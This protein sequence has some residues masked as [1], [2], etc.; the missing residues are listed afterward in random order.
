MNTTTARR[1][2]RARFLNWLGQ[3]AVCSPIG[4]VAVLIA[5]AIEPPTPSDA[6]GVIFILALFSFFAWIGGAGIASA[7][8]PAFNDDSSPAEMARDIYLIAPWAIVS[9]AITYAWAIF[10]LGGVLGIVVA[11]WRVLL[12]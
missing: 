4:V 5:C 10:I 3:V 1:P 11:G 7:V 2:F 9:T 8:D 12:R 6:A